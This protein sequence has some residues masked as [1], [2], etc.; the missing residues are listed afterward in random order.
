MDDSD[1]CIAFAP[2]FD[3]PTDR[4]YLTRAR[5]SLLATHEHFA[6]RAWGLFRGSPSDSVRVERCRSPRF[7]EDPCRHAVLFGPR[8]SRGAMV[9]GV[10]GVAFS[11]KDSLGLLVAYLSGLGRTAR[12][13][14][15]LRFAARVAPRPRKT[16]FRWVASSFRAG[17]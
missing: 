8:R 15:C 7:L 14:R 2:A 12:R 1:S 10:A 4:R 16:R 17:V 5:C 9:I 11:S 13:T 3:D 6:P